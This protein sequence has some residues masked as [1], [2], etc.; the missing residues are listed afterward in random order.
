MLDLLAF[1]L[2]GTLA[3]TETLKARSYGWAAQQLR[4]EIDPADVEAAYVPYV[5]GGREH[6]ATSLLHAFD[7]EAAARD[8][9]PSV[10]PWESFVTLRLGRY[11]A[12]LRDG[13]LV[14]AAALPA[15]DALARDGRR[16]A[17]HLAVVTTTDRANALPVLDALGLADHFDAVVTSDDVDTHKPDPE[18]YRLALARLSADP[19]RSVAVEDSPA[20]ARGAVA[21]GI[22]VLVL[23]SAYTR[24]GIRALVAGGV[25]PADAVTA[26]EALAEAVRQRAEAAG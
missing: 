22:P 8:H 10:E 21:A 14:R 23:P 25:L 4:P 17:R 19:A 24:D 18:G 1:D 3:D 13:N 20:G 5:G 7:L 12:M 16:Y 9:D 11:R 2:D 6:I 15:T 26:P